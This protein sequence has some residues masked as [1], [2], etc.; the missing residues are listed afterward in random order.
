VLDA[1]LARHV[2]STERYIVCQI[3]W[4]STAPVPATNRPVWVFFLE[5]FSHTSSFQIWTKSRE[6]VTCRSRLFKHKA[7][8]V[9]L[10]RPPAALATAACAANNSQKT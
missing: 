5:T 9:S 6:S 7:T 10:R 3:I 8:S 2:S 4:S 1:Q